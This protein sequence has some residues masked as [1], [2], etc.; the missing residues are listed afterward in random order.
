MPSVETV[1]ETCVILSPAIVILNKG[2]DLG[3]NSAKNLKAEILRLRFRLTGLIFLFTFFLFSSLSFAKVPVYE[4][5]NQIRKQDHSSALLRGNV[6]DIYVRV[7]ADKTSAY[8]GE[9]IVLQYDLMTRFDAAFEGF[10]SETDLKDFSRFTF[11]KEK[12]QSEVRRSIFF[13]DR[14]YTL[15]TFRKQVLF[16]SKAG[17]KEIKPGAVRVSYRVSPVLRKEMIL[18][19]DQTISL[20]ILDFP[21]TG[22]P[23]DFSGLA[24]AFKVKTLLDT[25][26][27][28]G[29]GTVQFR[30]SI[31]GNS[32]LHATTI[33]IF[34]FPEGLTALGTQADFKADFTEQGLV[35]QKQVIVLLKPAKAGSWTIPGME[36]SFYDPSAQKYKSIL[37]REMGF[38]ALELP[39]ES[40]ISASAVDGKVSALPNLQQRRSQLEESLKPPIVVP[41]KSPKPLKLEIKRELPKILKEVQVSLK[42]EKSPKEI[43]SES[44]TA[45][46][47]PAVSQASTASHS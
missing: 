17:Q 41:T 7:K 11:P 12:F 28:A 37:T 14:Q 10:E 46:Q 1:N 15:I 27:L 33:P 31:S 9:A 30:F 45:I 16:A 39:K 23:V 42:S 19:T 47:I 38:E 36:I 21:Q 29:A 26:E 3:I 44:P 2:K 24:G 25:S 13:V 18:K 6:E 35:I 22:K 5:M 8:P 34:E 20:G 32:D 43:K 4:Q 40:T